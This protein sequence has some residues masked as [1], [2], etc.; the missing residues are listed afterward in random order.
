[1]GRLTDEERA[2]LSELAARLN[3]DAFEIDAE[4]RPRADDATRK[5][6]RF[7]PWEIAGVIV[8]SVDPAR[9]PLVVAFTRSDDDLCFYP[10]EVLG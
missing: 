8:H 1:M 3:G 9:P 6:P 2:A 7:W 10:V 4:T 5:Q